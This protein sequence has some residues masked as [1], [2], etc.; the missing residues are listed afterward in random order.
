MKITPGD[1]YLTDS[2]ELFWPSYEPD[3]YGTLAGWKLPEFGEEGRG[4]SCNESRIVSKVAEPLRGNRQYVCLHHFPCEEGIT[5]AHSHS[6]SCWSLNAKR[7]AKGVVVY[8]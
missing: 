8:K 1:A 2:G 4:Y 3:N 5:S 7:G 6:A